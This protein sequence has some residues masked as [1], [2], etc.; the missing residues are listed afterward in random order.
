M[1]AA[2]QK[3]RVSFKWLVHM[4]TISLFVVYLSHIHCL[5]VLHIKLRF[6]VSSQ[7]IFLCSVLG[8]FPLRQHVVSNELISTVHFSLFRFSPLC[9]YPTQKVWCFPQTS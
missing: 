9:F 3:A 4:H 5:Y 8:N 1:G 7:S 6:V 2:G